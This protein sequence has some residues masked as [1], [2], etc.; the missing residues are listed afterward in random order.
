MKLE[1][2]TS[3]TAEIR[4]R[5]VWEMFGKEL[6]VNYRCSLSEIATKNR[7]DLNGMRSW[8]LDRGYSVSGLKKEV[9]HHHYGGSIPSAKE[10]GQMFTP[11]VASGTPKA[12]P[13]LRGIHITFNS[14]TSITV[15]EATPEGITDL[16]LSYERKEGELCTL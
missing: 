2:V 9:L 14:G 12:E 8:M 16:I 3:K 1:M 11:I 5:H 15:K 4:F 6:T 10:A 13:S 7:T